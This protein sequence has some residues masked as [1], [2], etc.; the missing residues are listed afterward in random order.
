LSQEMSQHANVVA[1]QL[2]NEF[3]P[4]MSWCHC[5]NCQARFQGWLKKRY[6]SI[7]ELNRLWGTGFWSMDYSDWRQVRLGSEP[8][9]Y[10]SRILDSKRFWSES[11]TSFA[12]QQAEIIRRNHPQA[13]VTT[14]GM[15]PIFQPID[16]Y[17]LF[18]KLD[19]ACDDLYF[20]IA[21]LDA[22]VAAMNVFRSL[23][24]GRRFWIT[25][26]GSGALDHNRPPHPDQFR[27]W[28]W[29]S[30]AHGAEAHLVFR[31]RTCLSGQEQELQGILEHSGTPRHRYQ[32]VQ[33]CFLELKRLWPEFKDLP[34]PE[35]PLAIV[36]DYQT[37][38]AY[39][40]A[41]VE[42]DVNY[43][44]LVYRLHKA[45]F[46]RNIL[47][48]FIPPERAL[49]GYRLVILPSTVIISQ[50]FASR[51]ADFVSSGGVVLAIGQVGMRDTNNN[52][53]PYPGPDHLQELLGVNIEGGMYL[54]S[55]VAPNEALWVPAPRQGQVEIKVAGSLA[56]RTLEGA[57]SGWAA[58][59]TFNGGELL[60]Q[61]TS[62]TYA[63]QPAVVQR[64]HGEG[65]AI[66]AGALRLDEN[67]SD[68]LLEHA[69]S[70]AGVQP[71]PK[72]PEYVEVIRR[73]EVV[74]AIN[75]TPQTVRVE[76]G[77][78]GQV[79]TGSFKEGV[80]ELGPYG[81]CAVKEKV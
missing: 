77:G 41:R 53:L 26:T 72:T 42:K 6:S 37:L 74:F 11:M 40:A 70:N 7:Q 59:L 66:Y 34:L 44:G 19:V 64:Q 75:H 57:A 2:D 22:N 80:A 32:A 52:Y 3:G 60:L 56:G 63:G 9:L 65:C 8:W 27:A 49:S 14:N 43:L 50:G 35:A 39:E 78:I 33:K 76:L 79:L 29:S 62:D 54:G 13:L 20:D 36:Q 12:L 71:G 58:D 47:V 45:L 48:D 25:E 5:E 17:E 23:K 69:L 30:L 38:W 10:P 81:V 24:P 61:F 51:L 28:A 4:E 67:L 46:D 18:G 55:F 31:W 15:G 21:T 68:S 73:G 1:W 16:Y